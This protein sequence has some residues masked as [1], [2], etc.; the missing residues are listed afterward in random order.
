MA[1][2]M[3]IFC[4]AMLAFAAVLPTVLASTSIADIGFADAAAIARAQNPNRP[5]LGM[6]SRTVGGVPLLITTNIDESN[7]LF[8]GTKL[9]VSDGTVLESEIESILPPTHLET[10][11]VLERLPELTLDFT[12]AI[13]IANAEAQQS[14]A[15]IQRIDLS[16][17]AFMVVFEVRY[18]NKH[19]VMVDGVTGRIVT[20]D[21]I[22]GA[23]NSISPT[24]FASMMQQ[25]HE[26]AGSIW[27]A[28]HA[29]T[30]PTPQGIASSVLLL[31]PSSGRVKQVEILGDQVSVVQFIPIGNLASRVAEIRSALATIVVTPAGFL[32][33]VE[34][35][36]P[37]GR[38]SGVA[39][40]SRMH[41][42]A[43]RTR[44]SAT[45][46]TAASTQVEYS[47]NATV[48]VGNGVALAQVAP[49]AA[50]LGDL[51]GDG[52]V[53]ANDLADF[54]TT[55]GQDY[56]PHDLDRDGAVLGSDLAILLENWG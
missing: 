42:G 32:A 50:V 8:Y 38:V 52:H 41:N 20:P 51:D 26:E 29:G 36:F 47:I 13:T 11:A 9:R 25:A 56:P 4:P 6:R 1:R 22:A 33:N 15:N 31:N 46:L 34:S 24:E 10:A 49:P 40:D 27:V 37:G 7:A 28:F 30:I 39:L 12:D 19:R 14:D 21:S 53:L 17:V 35:A 2:P 5:L 44:W 16:S 3:S 23:D 18:K 55:F 48:P 54:I 45:I 43:L